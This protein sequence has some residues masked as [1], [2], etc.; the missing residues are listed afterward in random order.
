MKNKPI[1]LTPE[2]LERINRATRAEAIRTGNVALAQ[3][4]DDHQA[5]QKNT[6]VPRRHVCGEIVQAD[7]T[8]ENAIFYSR[9]DTQGAGRSIKNCPSCGVLL[10]M[11]WMRALYLVEPMPYTTY[12]HIQGRKVCSNCWGYI[13]DMH[14]IRAYDFEGLPIME[15][16]VLLLCHD[17]GVETKG[18][19]TQKYVG[20]AREADHLD[21]GRALNGLVEAL[22]LEQPGIPVN[23]SKV[24]HTQAQ[25]LAELGF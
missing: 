15:R 7:I 17:C 1:P 19:V 8:G 4:L 12:L 6:I 2:E 3:E 14:D 5:A 22:E 24:K 9:F 18:Y 21:Y 16:H 25:N 10:S 23:V 20:Y 13:F 11:D